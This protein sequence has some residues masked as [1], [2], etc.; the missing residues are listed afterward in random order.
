MMIFERAGERKHSIVFEGESRLYLPKHFVPKDVKKCIVEFRK[1][2]EFE[3]QQDKV[4]KR[5]VRF[6]VDV[7]NETS[8]HIYIPKEVVSSNDFVPS[9]SFRWE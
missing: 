8:F 2:G 5:F 3:M 4:T 1:G 6:R 7:D 9:L